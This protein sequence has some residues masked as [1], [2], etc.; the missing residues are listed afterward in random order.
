MLFLTELLAGLAGTGP[1][2]LRDTLVLEDELGAELFTVQDL[3]R[4]QDRIEVERGG[5]RIATVKGA[6][7]A[8]A[9]RPFLNDVE[10]CEAI[11]ASENIGHSTTRSSGTA[12]TLQNVISHGYRIRDTYGTEIAL[13]RRWRTS[14]GCRVFRQCRCSPQAAGH[15]AKSSR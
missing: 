7:V 11:E 3:H 5:H 1:R 4:E 15:K 12:R 9:A 14:L 8:S 6:L 2:C 10:Y 13:A